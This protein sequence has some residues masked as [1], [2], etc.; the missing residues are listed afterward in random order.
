MVPIPLAVIRHIQP[1]GRVTAVK[2]P[3]NETNDEN[4]TP[5]T[6]QARPTDP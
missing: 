4:E 1:T 6:K 2:R 5:M 3:L